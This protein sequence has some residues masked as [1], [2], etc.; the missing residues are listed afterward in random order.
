MMKYNLTEVR[1]AIIKM[2]TNNKCQRESGEKETHLHYFGECKLG[3]VSM[4]KSMKFSQK[5]KRIIAYDSATSLLGIYPDKANSKRYMNP[6]FHR[7]TIHKSQ[8]RE[9]T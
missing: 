1:M 3:T 9:T 6:H 4:E 8:N 2:S 5:T 7:I